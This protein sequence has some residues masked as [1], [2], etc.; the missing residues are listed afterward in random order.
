MDLNQKDSISTESVCALGT[1][2]AWST[3]TW[4]DGAEDRMGSIEKVLNV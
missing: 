4:T 1:V 3:G 2:W